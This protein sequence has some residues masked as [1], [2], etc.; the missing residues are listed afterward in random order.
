[1]FRN[2]LS[3]TLVLDFG[4]LHQKPLILNIVEPLHISSVLPDAS[5]F[6]IDFVEILTEVGNIGGIQN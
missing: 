6:V 3:C 1:M 4:F 2:L 5:K